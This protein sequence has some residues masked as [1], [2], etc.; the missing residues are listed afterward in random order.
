MFVEKYDCIFCMMGF[1][2]TGE[3]VLGCRLKCYYVGKITFQAVVWVERSHVSN[4]MAL[5][6]FKSSL[7]PELLTSSQIA[8][9]TFDDIIH[10][11]I[12]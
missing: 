11:Q 4:N 3:P 12:I 7:I 6:V 10:L 2:Q 1:I 9:T 5:A 8:D